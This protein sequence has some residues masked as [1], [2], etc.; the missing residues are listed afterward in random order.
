MTTPADAYIKHVLDMMP[1][2]MPARSQIAMELRAHI[3]ERL[4]Q[5]HAIDQVLEQLGDPV[6]LANSYLAAE[7]LVPAAPGA[8]FAAKAIDFVVMSVL[9]APLTWRACAGQFIP[10]SALIFGMIIWTVVFSCVLLSIYTVIAEYA[11]GQ[12]IGKRA[13]GLTVVRESG[14]RIGLGQAVVRQLPLIF[15]VIWIDALFAL[16]TEKRQRAFELLSKT[17]TVRMSP[18]DGR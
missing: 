15:S 11:A 2:A 12:T 10:P 8:R 17:R 5:G 7:P 13:L 9:A 1:R 4:S 16:F 3:A 18:Q 14:L 6:K